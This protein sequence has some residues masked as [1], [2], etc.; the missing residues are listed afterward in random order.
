MDVREGRA[1]SARIEKLCRDCARQLPRHTGGALGWPGRAATRRGFCCS[2]QR[3]VDAQLLR[4]C[5]T[6]CLRFEASVQPADTCFYLKFA[7]GAQ[8]GGAQGLGGQGLTGAARPPTNRLA[9]PPPRPAATALVGGSAA[10]TP[11]CT[12]IQKPSLLVQRAI[13]KAKF[14]MFNAKPISFNA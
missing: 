14:I 5:T 1:D 2:Q 4:Y 9:R 7:Q 11:T 13:F 8:G 10:E 6:A 12:L 3:R